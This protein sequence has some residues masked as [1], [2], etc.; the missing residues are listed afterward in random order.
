MPVKLQ[1]VTLYHVD[2]LHRSP[3]PLPPSP[4]AQRCGKLRIPL[5][6]Q[7]CSH[8]RHQPPRQAPLPGTN[9]NDYVVGL[10]IEGIYDPIQYCGICEKVLT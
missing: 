3:F 4:S 7:H 1:R 10:R 2:V 5:N 6:R 8:P 9:L